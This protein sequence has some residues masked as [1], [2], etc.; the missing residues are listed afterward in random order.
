MSNYLFLLLILACPLMMVFMMRGMHSGR[1][2]GERADRGQHGDHAMS[3]D[4]HRAEDASLAELHQRRDELD[5]EIA[6]RMAEEKTP[7]GGGWR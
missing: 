7:V 2:E 5:R 3:L 1:G 6:K 4:G